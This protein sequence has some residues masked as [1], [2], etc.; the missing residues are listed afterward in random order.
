MTGWY[1]AAALYAVAWVGFSRLLINAA[2]LQGKEFTRPAL[3][4][5]GAV[6]PAWVT[7]GVVFG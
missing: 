6:W 2:R 1:V 3:W 7:W 4:A 5:T